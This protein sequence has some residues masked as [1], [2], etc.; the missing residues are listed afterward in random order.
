MQRARWYGTQAA[1]HQTVRSGG[2]L[3]R[4]QIS[5]LFSYNITISRLLDLFKKGGG[6]KSCRTPRLVDS[7][8]ISRN[9][10]DQF[11]QG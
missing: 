5:D 11:Y 4:P 3:P 7:I 1:A 2:L 10:K 8:S 6:K 9:L